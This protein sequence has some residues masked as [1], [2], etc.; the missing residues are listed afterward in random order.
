MAESGIDETLTSDDETVGQKTGVET[1][2]SPYAGDYVSDMIST[3]QSL[4]DMEYEPY[5][6]IL[7]AGEEQLQTDAFSG[8]SALTLPTDAEMGVYTP[9]SATDTYLDTI[10]NPETGVETEVTKNIID[11]YMNPY[12][13]AVVEDQITDLKKQA[14]IKRLENAA[15]MTAAGSYGGGRQAVLEGAF[16]D[17]LLDDISD[18]IK[19]G[20][21]EAYNQAIQQFNLEQDKKI[22]EQDKR[23]QY[24]FDVIDKQAELGGIKRGITQEGVEADRAQYNE[25]MNFPYKQVQFMQS[26]LQNLPLETQAYS[27]AEPSALADAMSTSGGLMKLYE[28]LFGIDT[29]STES[30]DTG[31]KDTGLTQEVKDY[32]DSVLNPKEKDNSETIVAT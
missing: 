18:A 5:D 11:K 20:N 12:K 19:T 32:I 10:I 27:Y 9:K 31:S 14:A 16:D 28:L 1:S 7:T 21:V 2:L 17:A 24:G 23:T 22:S 6:D 30:K 8:I 4:A 15:R 3:G 25:E 26:L 13:T 29:K